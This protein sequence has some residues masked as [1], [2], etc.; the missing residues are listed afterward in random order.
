MRENLSHN[1]NWITWDDDDDDG[2]RRGRKIFWVLNY[3][4]SQN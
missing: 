4:R 2:T 3:T 1:Q